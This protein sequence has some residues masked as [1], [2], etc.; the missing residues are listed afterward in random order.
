MPRL[1][2][3]YELHFSRDEK[4]LVVDLLQE[5]CEELQEITFSNVRYDNHR[6]AKDYSNKLIAAKDLLYHVRNARE[7]GNED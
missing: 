2:G 5:K 4:G 6:A 1:L 3:R 7:V